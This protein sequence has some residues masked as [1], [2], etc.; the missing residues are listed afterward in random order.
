M[1]VRSTLAPPALARMQVEQLVVQ[2]ASGAPARTFSVEIAATDQEK[3]VGLMFRTRLSDTEGM[4]FHYG[5]EQI[6][7]MWMRNTYIPLD[8]AFI[9]AKGVI[10]RIEARTE[11]LSERIISSEAPVAAVL[12]IAGG[13]AERLGLSAGDRVLHP[14]FEANAP[15]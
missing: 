2:P 14:L 11:P 15:P 6:I 10:H 3:A 8:M 7:T 9:T 5:R 4:L 1:A 13:A 12:E